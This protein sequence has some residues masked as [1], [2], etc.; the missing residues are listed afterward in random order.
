MNINRNAEGWWARSDDGEKTF[1]PFASRE[2]ARAARRVLR[3]RAE[4]HLSGEPVDI[5]G[6]WV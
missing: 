3:A 6:V 1:G 2:S 5:E 4:G